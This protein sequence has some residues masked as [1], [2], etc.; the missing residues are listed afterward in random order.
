MDLVELAGVGE[1][2]E[3]LA[4][5]DVVDRGPDNRRVLDFFRQR[6]G[7]SSITGNHERKHLR[8][9]NGEIEPALS[10]V[11]TRSQLGPDYP[12][13][14]AF[15]ATFPRHREFPE[16]VVVHGFWEPGLPLDQQ[17]DTVVIGTLSGE[18]YLTH[19]YD[20]AWWELY[21]GPKPLIVGH[22]DYR[23]DGQP[24]VYQDRV[25]AIDT[26]CCHGGRLTGLILP[27]FRFVSVPARADYWSETRRLSAHPDES[28]GSSP[29]P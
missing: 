22:H 21:D 29:G 11:I 5:G 4:V 14:L 9:A 20:R 19:R 27:D 26:G 16:A 15:L 25:F 23:R 12:A 3:I 7:A 6:P 17:R 1:G 2:D 24:L 18:H 28:G 10:Q 13:Y 8:S